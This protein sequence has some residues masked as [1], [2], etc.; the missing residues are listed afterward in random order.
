MTEL[1]F[2]EQKLNQ[3]IEAVCEKLSEPPD[4]AACS[5]SEVQ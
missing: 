3:N 2:I 1:L 4:P 5:S